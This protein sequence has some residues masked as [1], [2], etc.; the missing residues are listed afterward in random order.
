MNKKKKNIVK[1]K[2]PIDKGCIECPF[3]EYVGN[4]KDSDPDKMHVCD[5][6]WRGFEIYYCNITGR[7]VHLNEVENIY[8]L[9]ER[10]PL[11][12]NNIEVE[13]APQELDYWESCNGEPAFAEHYAYLHEHFPDTYPHP[14]KKEDD[15]SESD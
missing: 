7:R 3:S 4:T 2:V 10:C 5:K 14:K 8:V 9:P 1:I 13:I 6:C 11:W 12:S 15:E